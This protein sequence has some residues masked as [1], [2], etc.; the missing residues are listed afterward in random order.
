MTASIRSFLPTMLK[1]PLGRAILAIVAAAAI[2]IPMV[3]MQSPTA[4]AHCDSKDGPVVTAARE[5]L[6]AGDVTLVLP[7][8]KADQEQELTAAFDQ[9]LAIRKRG[10]EV[11]EL[12]DQYFF[13]TTVRLHRIGE[14]ASYT[15]IKDE[16]EADPALEA[17]EK[18]L[19]QG[20]PD[21]VINVLDDALRATVAERFQGVLDARAAEKANP[22]VE[23]SR[24]RVEAELMFEKYVLEIGA[25][26]HEE[27][28]H[29]EPA[30]GAEGEGH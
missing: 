7:Y 15:G 12:A 19:E 18:S 4:S 1:R 16:V 21:E 14:G 22:S 30:G 23:T 2:A 6:E 24:E 28:S 17:A 5:A 8:V 25:A 13:E 10:P 26:I 27:A 20:T 3:L 11:K 29:E 9:T